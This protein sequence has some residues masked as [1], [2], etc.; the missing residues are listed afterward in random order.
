[1]SEQE[2][3][4]KVLPL[5]NVVFLLSPGKKRDFRPH[6]KVAWHHPI[7]HSRPILAL[8]SASAIELFF[9]YRCQALTCLMQV[10]WPYTRSWS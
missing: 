7:G 2:N 10:F 6:M 8:Q 1:M 3:T 9:A 5:Q 4:T